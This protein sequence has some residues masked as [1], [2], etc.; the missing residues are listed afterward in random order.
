LNLER[1]LLVASYES[2]HFPL[3]NLDNTL[4]AD[5][6]YGVSGGAAI[7]SKDIRK[8]E[9]SASQP[10]ATEAE[11]TAQNAKVALSDESADRCYVLNHDSTEE[12]ETQVVDME[13]NHHQVDR[14]EETADKQ[15]DAAIQVSAACDEMAEEQDYDGNVQQTTI[16]SRPSAV[17]ESD[18]QNYVN[19][20]NTGADTEYSARI[21]GKMTAG[22]DDGKVEENQEKSAEA[23][24]ESEENVERKPS[25]NQSQGDKQVV[26]ETDQVGAAQEENVDKLVD[27]I[28]QVGAACYETEVEQGYD[29]S[30]QE[31]VIDSVQARPDAV[32]DADDD[33]N[34]DT[35]NVDAHTD[36]EFSSGDDNEKLEENQEKATDSAAESEGYVQPIPPENTEQEAKRHAAATKIQVISMEF[37]SSLIDKLSGASAWTSTKAALQSVKAGRGCRF[38]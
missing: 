33:Y 8:A 35:Q 38:T 31:A 18:G 13:K 4:S 28:D 29:G 27:E 24:A 9:D 26:D 32:A 19:F 14:Q 36:K 17:V 21:E 34:E 11:A 30:D 23:V 5:D 16:A 2:L 3:Q 1:D 37:Y 15:A 12:V 22:K 20:Q 7:E 6:D 25:E 10:D